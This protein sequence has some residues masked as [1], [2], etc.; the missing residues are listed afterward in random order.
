M[1]FQEST[2]AQRRRT[3]RATLRKIV[4]GGEYMSERVEALWLFLQCGIESDYVSDCF[5]KEV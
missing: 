3:V 5:W 4:R 2:S 1:T